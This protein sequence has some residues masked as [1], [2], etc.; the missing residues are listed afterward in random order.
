MSNTYTLVGC[1]TLNMKRF[2]LGDTRM[3][4]P[5][6]ICHSEITVCLDY[7]RMNETHQQ[8]FYCR[9]CD[10]EFKGLYKSEVKMQFYTGKEGEI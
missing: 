6:P 3:N 1:G 10:K 4:V 8:F 7:P 5:C 2:N 9:E